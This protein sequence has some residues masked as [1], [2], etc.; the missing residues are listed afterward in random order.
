MSFVLR[1]ESYCQLDLRSDLPMCDQQVKSAILST[2]RSAILHLQM[3]GGWGAGTCLIGPSPGK[4]RQGVGV[5]IRVPTSRV[6]FRNIFIFNPGCE[7]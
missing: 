5:V 1:F 4:G 6:A 2:C 3:M 7:K